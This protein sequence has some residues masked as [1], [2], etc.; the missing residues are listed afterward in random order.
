MPE[1]VPDLMKALKESLGMS[2]ERVEVREMDPLTGE[3]TVRMSG[4]R[5]GLAERLK[6]HRQD[7]ERMRREAAELRE[8]ADEETNAA[9]LI[10]HALL[11]HSQPGDDLGH[12]LVVVHGPRKNTKV[13]RDEVERRREELEDLGLVEFVPQPPPPP[14]IEPASV[15]RFRACE[16]ELAKRGIRLDDLLE[17]GGPGDP[18]IVSTEVES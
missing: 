5:S 13:R 1:H 9:N 6:E 17:H 12:G 10:E 7:A 11:Q 4:T 16:V 2:D 18:M 14:K 8:K 3:V 15:T